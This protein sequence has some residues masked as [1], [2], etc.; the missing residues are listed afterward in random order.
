M[1]EEGGGIPGL[2]HDLYLAVTA[3]SL[4]EYRKSSAHGAGGLQEQVQRAS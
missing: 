3:K 2:T 1:P 4:F